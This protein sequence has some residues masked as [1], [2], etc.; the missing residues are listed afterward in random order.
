MMSL[1]MNH[2]HCFRERRH[3]LQYRCLLLP[4]KQAQA[5]LTTLLLDQKVVLMI[6]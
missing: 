4:A 2:C 3:Q 6:G 5:L 1:G